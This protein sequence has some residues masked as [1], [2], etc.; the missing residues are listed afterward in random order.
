MITADGYSKESGLMPEGVVVTWGADMVKRVG[1][2]KHLLQYFEEVMSSEEALFAQLSTTAPKHEIIHVYIIVANR[3]YCRVNFVQYER[4][5]A[6]EQRH[7]PAGLC[8]I[9][10][11]RLLLTGPIERCPFKRRLP[12]FR[13]FRYCTK[14]F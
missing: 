6:V 14:L 8:W 7:C 9:R 3:L 12:G 2:L 4:G 5:G 11:P 13:G 1:G 10:W